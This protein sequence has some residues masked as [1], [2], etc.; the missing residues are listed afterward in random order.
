MD[1]TEGVVMGA[2]EEA[3]GEEEEVA[4]VDKEMPMMRGR[5]PGRT[6]T[7]RGKRITTANEDTIGRWLEEGRCRVRQ[8]ESPFYM[9]DIHRKVV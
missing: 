8:L 5:E 4:A 1:S 9:F 6:R 7:N 3:E 2:V